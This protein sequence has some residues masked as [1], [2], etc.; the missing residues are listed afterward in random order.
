MVF[1]NLLPNDHLK[2]TNG[3][4]F[5]VIDKEQRICSCKE[6]RCHRHAPDTKYTIESVNT[7]KKYQITQEYINQKFEKNEISETTYY[8]GKWN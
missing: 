3:E 6:L 4:I 7:R 1:K 2:N 5:R 8:R